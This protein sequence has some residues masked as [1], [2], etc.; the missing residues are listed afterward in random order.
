MPT[1]ISQLEAATDVTASDLIQVIDIEDTGMATS[2]TNK[3]CTAQLMAN[4]LGKLTNITA[5]GSNT[6]R[7]LANRFAD[8]VNVK[9]F[10]AVGD[11]VTDDTA[12]FNSIIAL[13]NSSA[14][15]IAAKIPA[16]I[17]RITSN[18]TTINK[19]LSWFGSGRSTTRLNFEN[20]NGFRYDLSAQSRTF[21]NCTVSNVSILTNSNTHTGFYFKGKQTFAPHDAVLA[22]N[23]VSFDSVT[24]YIS[25]GASTNEWA[26]GLFIEDA[27]EI[28]LEDCYIRGS[29]NNTYYATRTSSTG[30]K[31]IDCTGFKA[32][33]CNLYLMGTGFDVS[34]QSEGHIFQG[35]TVVAVNQGFYYHDLVSPSNNHTFSDTHIAAYTAGINFADNAPTV[36]AQSV[37]V[38]GC[39]I[40][41]REPNVSKSS[42]KSII[43]N[44]RYSTIANC[45]LQS[46][47]T[48]TANRLGIYLN[49]DRNLVSNV[50]FYNPGVLFEVK[51]AGA[52][53]Y[54]QAVNCA[55]IGSVSNITTGDDQFLLLAGIASASAKNTSRADVFE[56]ESLDKNPKLQITGPRILLGARDSST[57]YID[58]LSNISGTAAYDGRIL[59]SG[60]S[61]TSGQADMLYYGGSHR[62]SQLIIPQTDNLYSCGS[63]A[64]RWSQ[65]FSANGT[66][67]T[68]DGREKQQIRSI[69]DSE[70]VV[71]I[72]LKSLI[73]A[74]KWND[75]VESKGDGA[76]IHFGVIAQDVKNAFEEEGL[77]PEDYGMFCYDEWESTN[78]ITDEDG[79]IVIQGMEAGNAFGVRYNELF[80]FIIANL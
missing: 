44:C 64:F 50:V 35:C 70:K 11:G 39:F 5:T 20:C 75:A 15:G 14:N 55:T 43:F 16:G 31:I 24:R 30:V 57:R 3:K 60:G 59:S 12:A 69:T 19:P 32:N 65:I 63:S 73:R 76:R 68:S 66:I 8:V 23:G 18:L 9:D 79:N 48:D 22:F 45:G 51:T 46:N 17:Y 53:I 25:G 61:S 37:F 40:L 4:E 72:K 67:N 74:Y 77:N 38:N 27:D 36:N 21:I 58:F 26:T 80:A 34:G 1:K 52:G 41:E 29:D 7:S 28:V 56:F 2:G 49:S 54:S 62:F 13:A 42:Y 47:T 78:D 6:A 33:F 10:G 71:A